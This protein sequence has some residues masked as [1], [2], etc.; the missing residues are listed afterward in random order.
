[1]E[2]NTDI[3]KIDCEKESQRI[4]QFIR[5]QVFENFRKRGIVIGISGGI[6]PIFALYYT[7]RSESFEGKRFKVF[8]ST[9]EAYLKQHGLEKEAQESRDSEDL[10]KV[11]L[12]RSRNDKEIWLFGKLV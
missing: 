6:E 8:H 9:V 3:L 10:K 4:E 12:L 1:M 11:R 7:R 5:K 2:F